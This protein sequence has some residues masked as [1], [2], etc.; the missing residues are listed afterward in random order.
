METIPLMKIDKSDPHYGFKSWNDF[1]IRTFA[2]WDKTRPLAEDAIVVASAD[3]QLTTWYHGLKT[4]GVITCKG[5]IYSLNDMLCNVPHS[6]KKHFE[7][8]SSYQAFLSATNYHRYHSPV[9]GEVLV[10]HVCP[11]S[12]YLMQDQRPCKGPAGNSQC[13]PQSQASEEFFSNVQ[14]RAIFIVNN[15]VLGPVAMI[16]IGMIE[17]SS[18]MISDGIKPG[19]HVS[20]GQELGFFQYGG[21]THVVMFGKEAFDMLDFHIATEKPYP[22]KLMEVRSGVAS[23]KK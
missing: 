1:F 10:A 8:G 3:S 11:G 13:L 18:C 6:L 16:A 7:G 2:D 4:N 21:S 19:V 17:V 5:D 14:T 12:Y 23:L 22:Q 9:E 20:K 15:P